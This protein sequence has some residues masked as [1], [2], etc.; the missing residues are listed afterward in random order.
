MDIN[1]KL[2]RNSQELR[3]N[4]TEEERK[5]WYTFL[6]NLPV[7]FRRQYVIDKYIVDFCCPKEKLVIELDGSQHYD[8]VVEATDKVRD[9]R[10]IELGYRVLRFSNLDI[11]TRFE[12]VCEEIYR[13]L[14]TLQ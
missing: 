6:N 4:L 2:R 13:N 9:K 1:L 7:H 5:L 10:L 14:L 3:K 8:G 12:N 11:S